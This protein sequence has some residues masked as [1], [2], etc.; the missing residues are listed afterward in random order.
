MKLIEIYMVDKISCRE[1]NK[2]FQDG[3]VVRLSCDFNGAYHHRMSEFELKSNPMDCVEKSVMSKKIG[4]VLGERGVYYNGNVYPVF[5]VNKIARKTE[6][7]IA[8]NGNQ[9]G[10]QLLGD[11][12]E[13]TE[14]AP[15][16][17]KIEERNVRVL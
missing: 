14:S 5:H 7:S 1:C 4:L 13:L 9:S 15:F 17:L 10:H 12:E 11:L 6:I 2:Q 3:E 16:E 8:Y